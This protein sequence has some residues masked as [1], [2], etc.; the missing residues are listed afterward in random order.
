MPAAPS[1]SASS[2]RPPP[3]SRT[4]ST[5]RRRRRGA[6]AARRTASSS[7]SAASRRQCGPLN[8]KIQQMR[9]NLDRIQVDLERLR[10]DAGARARRPA[11][12]HPGGAR[13]KQL[14]PAVPAAGRGCPAAAQRRLVRV[15]VRPDARSF[16]AGRRRHARHARRRAAPSAPS[17]CAPATASIIRSR[18][19]PARHALPTTRR[20]ASVLPGRRGAA[21]LASQSRRGHQPGGVGRRPAALHG[22]AERVPLSHGARPDLQL[23][24]ARRKLVAG[25]EERRGH[26]RRAGRHRRERPARPAVVA[27]ARR[28]AGQADQARAAPLPR[29]PIRTGSRRHLPQ[30]YGCDPAASAAGRGAIEADPNRTVRAVGP[31]FIPAP[32]L[33]RKAARSRIPTCLP[34]A[35]QH[36]HDAL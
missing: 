12:R 28:C 19:P 25:A 23:P 14:R 10:G 15:A 5:A 1:S 26:H 32:I 27:A 22:A 33:D 18:P 29:G 8:N 31:T 2:R 7:C 24:A 6:P 16:S 35:L 36:A 34:S 4:R 9:D 17:A 20:P 21:L 11:P 30:R 13:A 3:T